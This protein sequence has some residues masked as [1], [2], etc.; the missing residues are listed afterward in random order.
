MA[1]SSSLLMSLVFFC[2]H[3]EVET[4]SARAQTGVLIEGRVV[5]PNG[6]P[7]GGAHVEAQTV[8]A[9]TST[10]LVQET[11]ANCDGKFSIKSFDPTC[12]KYKFSVS[13]RETFYLPT[14]DNI[15]YIDTNGA[16]PT[17]ELVSGQV[18]APIVLRLEQRGGEVVLSVFDEKT[19]SFIYA[20]LSIDREPVANKTFGGGISIATGDDGSSHTLF[21]P[22]G[23]YTVTV[24]RYMC[25]GKSYVAAR[26]P[27]FKFS[28]KA[29]M[30]EALTLKV[31]IAEIE[32][33]SSYDNVK[34]APCFQ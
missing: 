26:P 10:H 12:N 29:G 4:N 27:I 33:T 20:G 34:A 23:D 28:I 13:H 14:G 31:N 19:Q 16:T 9:N 25:H 17:I 15:F 11:T 22:P 2:F 18:F 7:A 21:L 5:Y 1:F 24:D 32:T 6:S 3:T 8:C 30:R